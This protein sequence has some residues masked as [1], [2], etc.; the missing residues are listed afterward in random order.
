MEYSGERIDTNNYQMKKLKVMLASRD[1][2]IETLRTLLEQTTKQKDEQIE[3]LVK[4]VKFYSGK[5]NIKT[6]PRKKP[7]VETKAES[8]GDAQEG[9]G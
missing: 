6:K 1:A 4:R 5:R 3:S 2:E 8:L 7:L 9:A